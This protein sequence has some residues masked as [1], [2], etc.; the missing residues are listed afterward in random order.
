[1]IPHA[2]AASPTGSFHCALARCGFCD[3][4]RSQYSRHRCGLGT[5]LPSVQSWMC[6][7]EALQH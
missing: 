2:L 1:M 4:S 7:V 3:F 6:T 5:H